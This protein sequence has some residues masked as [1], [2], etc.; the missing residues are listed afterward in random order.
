MK[1]RTRVKLI[2]E[3]DW[4]VEVEVERIDEPKG[5]EPTLSLGG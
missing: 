2:R 5:W 4:V 3:G 1:P